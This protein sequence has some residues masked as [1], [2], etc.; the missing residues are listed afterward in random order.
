V[1]PE[2]RAGRNEFTPQWALYDMRSDPGERKNLFDDHRDIATR[3]MKA[4]DRWFDDVGRTRGY[5]VPRIVAGTKHENPVTLTRQDWRGPRADWGAKGLGHWDVEFAAG[6]YDV[7][8]RMPALAGASPVRLRIG[9]IELEQ[10]VDAGAERVTFRAIRIPG[11]TARV[12][13]TVQR[14]GGRVGAHYVD[15]RFLEPAESD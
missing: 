11:G 12:A 5:P 13:A 7:T 14:E 10:P 8:V 4:Y 1:Q 9:P 2:G 3:M 15:L 6:N